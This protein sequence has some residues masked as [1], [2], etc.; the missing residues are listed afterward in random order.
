MEDYLSINLHHH[1]ME[2]ATRIKSD[3]QSGTCPRVPDCA[4]TGRL[5]AV[6]INDAPNLQVSGAY[7]T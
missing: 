1:D 4:F 2:E 3:C 5:V 7:L 6:Q